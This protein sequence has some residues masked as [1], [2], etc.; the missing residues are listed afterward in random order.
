MEFLDKLRDKVAYYETYAFSP[1]EEDFELRNAMKRKEMLFEANKVLG[2]IAKGP[3]M[4]SDMVTR[5]YRKFMTGR[6]RNKL[7]LK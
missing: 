3:N 7:G 5:W 6:L 4:G 2:E 1:V